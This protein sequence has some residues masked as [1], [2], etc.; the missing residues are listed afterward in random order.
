MHREA[1]VPEPLT[2]YLGAEEIDDRAASA[3]AEHRQRVVEVPCANN[4]LGLC[5]VVFEE[6]FGLPKNIDPKDA[7]LVVTGVRPA[8]PSYGKLFADHDIITHVNEVRVRSLRDLEDALG[9][10]AEGDIVPIQTYRLRSGETGFAR[11]RI[12]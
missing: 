9:D 10:V 5:L 7:G 3:R 8:G 1:G 12:R 4:P 2:V 6:A 11:I